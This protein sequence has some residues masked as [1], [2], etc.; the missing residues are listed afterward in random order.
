[1]TFSILILFASVTTG[2]Q[3]NYLYA[4]TICPFTEVELCDLNDRHVRFVV[5]TFL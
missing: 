4:T 2:M 1:M 3:T 5:V